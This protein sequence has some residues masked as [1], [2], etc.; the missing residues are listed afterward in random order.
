MLTCYHRRGNV[1]PTVWLVCRGDRG[2]Y[3]L[4]HYNLGPPT[5]SNRNHLNHTLVYHIFSLSIKLHVS[6]NFHLN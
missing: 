1:A 3:N 4:F 2:G 6:I 5:L